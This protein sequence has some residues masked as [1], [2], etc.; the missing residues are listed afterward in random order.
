MSKRPTN[1]LSKKI[2]NFYRRWNIPINENEAFN[3]FKNRTLMTIDSTLSM[4]YS[5]SVSEEFFFIVGRAYRNYQDSFDFSVSDKTK[6]CKFLDNETNFTNY[7]FYLQAIFWIKDLDKFK[8]E[9]LFN[10]FREAIKCS[11]LSINLVKVH[12]DYLFY[13]A[14][15]KLLDQYLVDDVL[16]WIENYQD[17]YENFK[18]AIEKYNQKRYQRN[19]IDD[20]RVSLELLLKHILNNNKSL[21]NQIAL[22]KGE[23]APLESYLKGKSVGNEIRTMYR[24]L[25]GYYTNYQNEYAKHPDKLDEP[26]DEAEVEFLIYLTGTFIRFLMLVEPR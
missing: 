16:N 13:P 19:L 2:A 15:A 25:I 9:E 26:V 10:A 11:Y 24:T 14:G 12:D 21:E 17:V 18:N 1:T 3:A 23:I 6:I 5:P 20:L 4:N 7:L 8:K 22:K